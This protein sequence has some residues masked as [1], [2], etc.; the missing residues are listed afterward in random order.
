M[1]AESLLTP[2]VTGILNDEIKSEKVAAGPVYSHSIWSW[3]H[4]SVD[5]TWV[6]EN[7]AIVLV[8]AELAVVETVVVGRSVV[9]E[10]VP[11]DE[12][13]EAGPTVERMDRGRVGMIGLKAKTVPRASERSAIVGVRGQSA[14]H[15]TCAGQPRGRAWTQR[16]RGGGGGLGGDSPGRSGH[17]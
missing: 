16:A 15:E 12:D 9:V 6:K 10:G 2:S 5:W 3:T 11:E 17:R 4:V 7:E 14:C 13:E 8:G 1:L